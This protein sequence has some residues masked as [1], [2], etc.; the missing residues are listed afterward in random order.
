M[1][2][3]VAV[4]SYNRHPSWCTRKDR[5]HTRY[6]VE[7]ECRR[8]IEMVAAIKLAPLNRKGPH[9]STAKAIALAEEGVYLEGRFEHLP[10]GV[11]KR[12]RCDR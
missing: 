10:Q 9:L 1:R 4:V 3:D 12:S 11:L 6:P 7:R 2:P 5:G 8:W